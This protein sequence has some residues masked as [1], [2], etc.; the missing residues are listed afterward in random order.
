MFTYLTKNCIFRRDGLTGRCYEMF[1]QVLRP[2]DT[3]L[4]GATVMAHLEIRLA[5]M[6]FD[7][8]V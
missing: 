7:L 1:S 6:S 2:S 4:R 8:I 3:E 5:N